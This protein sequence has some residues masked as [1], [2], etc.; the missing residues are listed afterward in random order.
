M[1]K[2]LDYVGQGTVESAC[3]NNGT[4]MVEFLD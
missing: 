4:F 2:N 1:G 3:R